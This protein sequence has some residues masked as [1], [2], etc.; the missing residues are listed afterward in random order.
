MPI[1]F[2]ASWRPWPSAMPAAETVWAIRKP[3]L[4]LCG[5]ALRNIHRIAH[6]TR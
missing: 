2:C 6:M 3:R 5:L 1:V 4:A